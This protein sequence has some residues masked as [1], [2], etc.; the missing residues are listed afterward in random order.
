MPV[1]GIG[2]PEMGGKT[3]IAGSREALLKA[4]GLSVE[5][6]TDRI[7]RALAKDSA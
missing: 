6:I 2:V 3:S 1:V 7:E 5:A 4:A